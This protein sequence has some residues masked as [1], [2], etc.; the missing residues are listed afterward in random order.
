MDLE[1]GAIALDALK[2]RIT[3]VFPAQI[4]ACLDQ[5]S[6]EEIWSRPNES[7]NSIGN[8]ILHVTGSL[9]HYLNRNFGSVKF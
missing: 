9:N 7:T 6:D 4:R 8:I 2:I 1:I 5:L 3:K